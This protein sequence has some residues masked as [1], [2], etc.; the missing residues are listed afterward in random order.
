MSY[1]FYKTV[2]NN[3]K[4]FKKA[5]VHFLTTFEGQKYTLLQDSIQSVKVIFMLPIKPFAHLIYP[6]K[7]L[8][9]QKHLAFWAFESRFAPHSDVNI[10][11]IRG[12]N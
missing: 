2:N 1:A 4:Q 3:V 10:I 11:L 9:L 7:R 12:L 6:Q 8:I 5:L